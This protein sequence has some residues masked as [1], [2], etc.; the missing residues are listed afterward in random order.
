MSKAQ[1]KLESFFGT[2]LN[3]NA[4]KLSTKVQDLKVS[5]VFFSEK[6][7]AMLFVND[8]YKSN[9]VIDKEIIEDI[10]DYYSIVKV[11][12]HINFIQSLK[13]E[14]SVSTNN[15]ITISIFKEGILI[16]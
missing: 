10:K 7:S 5:I 8:K 6:P 4:K 13:V 15:D 11:K 1:L 3:D 2:Y 9:V 14:F 16:S 12:Y